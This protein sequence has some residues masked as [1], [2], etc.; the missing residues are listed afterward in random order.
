MRRILIGLIAITGLLFQA[1]DKELSGD[2]YDFSN[3]LPP[4]VTIST[5]AAED[6]QPGDT[7]TVT[8]AMR[9]AMQQEVTVNYKVEGAFT[10]AN[11]TITIERNKTSV[12]ANIP[13]PATTPVDPAG[14]TATLTLVSATKADGSPL[15]I[16]QR[17]NPEAQKVVISIIE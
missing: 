8:F 16:G 7:A 10:L 13:V 9:T 3:S 12:V 2:D 15:T 17:N 5:S 14:T 1:C 11:Q 6:L 4:C